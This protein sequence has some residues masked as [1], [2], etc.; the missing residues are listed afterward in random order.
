MSLLLLKDKLAVI[1]GA[2]S[3]IGAAVAR[4][5]ARRGA[6]LALVDVDQAGLEATRLAIPQPSRVSLHQMDVRDQGAIDDLPH[7]VE[8]AQQAPADILINNAGVALEGQFARVP[9]PD[10]DWVLDINLHAPIRLTR[11]FLPVLMQRPQAHIVNVSSIFG[12]IAPPG[13][14]AYATAKFG[15]R[16]FTESLRHELEDSPVQVIQVHPGGIATSIGRNM[17]HTSNFTEEELR[18]REQA[19]NAMLK[20]PPD[21]AAEVIVTGMEQ[22]KTRILIGSDA[23]KMDVIQRLLPGRYWSIL[24]KAFGG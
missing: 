10:F 4:A 23:K 13:Q 1:T 16:G 15:L 6:H 22:G 2:G 14:A 9:A 20:M 17:R 3:G 5:L 7:A 24:R 18:A 11:A 19:I 21:Q 12:I 8:E